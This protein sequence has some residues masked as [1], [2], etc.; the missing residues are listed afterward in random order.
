MKGNENDDRKEKGS[1]LKK[2]SN[3]NETNKEKG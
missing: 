3:L 2:N 1:S